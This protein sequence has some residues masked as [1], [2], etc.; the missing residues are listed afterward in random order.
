MD[1]NNKYRYRLEKYSPSVGKSIC[2]ACGE[3]TFVHYIDTMDN[4]RRVCEDV[5]GRCDRQEKCCY[6]Y[7]PTQFFKDIG[8]NNNS[9]LPSQYF[10]YVN[11]THTTNFSIGLSDTNAY[12]DTMDWEDVEKSMRYCVNDFTLFLYGYLKE[13]TAIIDTLINDYFIGG[14]PYKFQKINE[15]ESKI[16]GIDVI[17]WQVD[18]N[19]MVR[20]GKSM[21]YNIRT[22]KR[23][24]KCINW[25]HRDYA[26]YVLKQCL[27]GE[28][29]ITKYPD[30]Q[31]IWIVESEKTAL[32]VKGYLMANNIDNIIVL[33][34]GG[35]EQLNIKKLGIFKDLGKNIMLINDYSQVAA[36]KWNNISKKARD[37]YNINI[38]CVCPTL[39][40]KQFFGKLPINRADG[41]D[42][43]DYFHLYWRNNKK[44]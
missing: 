30:I 14:V 33:A 24:H 39:V 43:A 22:G 12:F 20:T 41:S 18:I 44:K 1:K 17:F 21:G 10:K 40:F 25:E 23:L 26:D 4:N 9:V 5:V 42:L 34:T 31:D 2:P 11:T 6:N 13:N 35:M 15:N 38:A 7:T 29:L 3:K 16:V 37:F 28:H 36:E 32:M 27:Y 19:N 8:L